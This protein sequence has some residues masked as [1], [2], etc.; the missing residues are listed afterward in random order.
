M[1]ALVRNIPNVLTGLRLVLAPLA[2]WL[3]LEGDFATALV[4][5]AIA[6]L[7][8]A[9]DG[10]LAKRYGLETRFGAWLDPAADKL[11]MLLCFL[12][13]SYVGITPRWLTALV[14]GRDVL[15]VLG[16]GIATLFSMPVRIDP[17]PIGKISTIVQVGYIAAMLAF[18]AFAV[19]SPA[20]VEALGVLA[21]VAT[22]LSGLGYGQ[23]FLRALLPGGKTA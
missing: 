15:I 23:L 8:D 20:S 11:L 13:L 6:G 21:A 1:S 17:L 10:Y 19:D 5:F 9:A 12:A 4:V 7:S 18:A 3:I 16:V 22:I 14:I 2:A